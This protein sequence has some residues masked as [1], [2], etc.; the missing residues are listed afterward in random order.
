MSIKKKQVAAVVVEYNGKR[1]Y[2]FC[3]KSLDSNALSGYS[4]GLTDSRE[5][6]LSAPFPPAERTP[7][8]PWE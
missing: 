5:K 8:N 4:V 1:P 7:R 6:R 3:Q 2:N